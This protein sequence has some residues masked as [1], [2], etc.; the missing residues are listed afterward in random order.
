MKLV[1]AGGPSDGHEFEIQEGNNLVGRW[2][3]DDV[4][5]PEI[6]LEQVD[7]EAKVSRK[8]CVIDRRGEQV[9]IEDVG[10]KNGT[11]I[12]K[13]HKLEP[14]AP[15]TLKDGDEILIGRLVLKFVV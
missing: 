12:N 14:G 10:S 8:H 3:P 4:A 11:Y 7:E 6:D 5:F 1:V 2:D 13:S 15:Y 9:T